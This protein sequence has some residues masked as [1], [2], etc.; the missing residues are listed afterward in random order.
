MLLGGLGVIFI[1]S[2]SQASLDTIN[3]VAPDSTSVQIGKVLYNKDCLTCHGPEGKGDGPAGRTLNPRPADLSQHAVL[4][5][6]TDT[7]LFQWISQGYPGTPMGGFEASL[8]ETERW[9]L[10][11]YIRTLAVK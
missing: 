3:P 11:N 5:V 1:F 2:P 4:G 10:V 7:K 9:N 8:S 6:H